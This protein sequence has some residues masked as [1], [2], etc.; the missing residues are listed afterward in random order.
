MHQANKLAVDYLDAR[1]H[2]GSWFVRIED[3]D[4]PREKP[5]SAAGILATLETFN[6]QWDGEVLY[7]S[8]RHAAYAE[9]I[10]RL[11]QERKA[12]YC[13]CSR[14]QL[15]ARSP[16]GEQGFIYPGTCRNA[17]KHSLKPRSI[18]VRTDGAEI[19]FDDR[20][21]GPHRQ[22]LEQELGDFVIRRAD[23]LFAGVTEVF[24]THRSR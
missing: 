5:G 16:P 8:Q 11:L 22:S 1:H 21:Q 12:F 24:R 7:Q 3:V 15:A 10:E 18:R 19:A 4:K 6:M 14:K 2:D 17:P 13:S 9:A 20:I 23:G